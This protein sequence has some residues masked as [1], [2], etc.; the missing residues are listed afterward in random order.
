M[1]KAGR[2]LGSDVRD[3]IVEILHELGEG[4]AYQVAKIYQALFRKVTLRVIYYHLK[5]GISTGEF[6][7]KDIKKEKGEYSWG[8]DAEKTYYA[9]GPK[10]SPYGD[11]RVREYIDTLK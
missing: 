4:Y 5:K 7:I 3:H 9:L 10:A 6:I 1:K 11:N 2:P 8:P